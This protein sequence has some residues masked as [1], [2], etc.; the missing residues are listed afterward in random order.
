MLFISKRFQLDES[1][2]RTIFGLQK[3]LLSGSSRA[4]PVQW[5]TLHAFAEILHPSFPLSVEDSKVLEATVLQAFPNLTWADQVRGLW[6]IMANKGASKQVPMVDMTLEQ[7]VS[8]ART[9]T[10]ELRV[11]AEPYR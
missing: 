9:E 1:T 2:F 4:Q 11:A 3:K 10:V 6:G 5:I 8:W 7:W